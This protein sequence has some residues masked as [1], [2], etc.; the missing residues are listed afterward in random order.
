MSSSNQIYG[1]ALRRLLAVDSVDSQISPG[2]HRLKLGHLKSSLCLRRPGRRLI[3][4]GVKHREGLAVLIERQIE[5]VDIIFTEQ[6]ASHVN[7]RK[8]PTGRRRRSDDST[9]RAEQR[10]A[11]DHWPEISD[12]RIAASAT[13][14]RQ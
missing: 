12:E 7:G 4:L 11:A 13:A 14:G 8:D 2:W 10:H 3:I 1:K 9:R 6:L 5:V